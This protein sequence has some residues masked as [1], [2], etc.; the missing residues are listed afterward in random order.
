MGTMP[1]WVSAAAT[2]DQYA[3][4]TGTE[5][6]MITAFT[7]PTANCRRVT[8]MLEAAGL[9]WQREPVDRAARQHKTAEFIAMNA[10]A[11]V[12][13]IIDTDGPGGERLVLSQSAA[14][15]IYLGEKSGRFLP[16]KGKARAHALE[17]LMQAMTD[18]NWAN[19]AYYHLNSQVASNDAAKAYITE[20]LQ[21]YLGHSEQRLQQA[22][23]LGGD[24][25]SVADFALLP[26]V[27]RRR[28]LI[29]SWNYP[30]LLHWLDGLLAR[31]EIKRGLE[32]A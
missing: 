30:R 22:E 10:A 14:I 29:A 27:N 9:D 1:S 13:V 8:V 12:P 5:A 25:M 19:S 32:A 11:M 24:E 6:D 4:T 20:R 26:V 7:S 28:E 21:R 16:A 3:P 2:S 31:P 15:L 17:A 23:F 18:V